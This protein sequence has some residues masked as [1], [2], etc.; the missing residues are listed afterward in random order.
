VRSLHGRLSGS[1][2]HSPFAT[3]FSLSRLLDHELALSLPHLFH[4]P[5]AFRASAIMRPGQHRYLGRRPGLRS[6]S[7]QRLSARL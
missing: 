1:V 5:N 7:L 4:Y 6:A 3:A 2:G